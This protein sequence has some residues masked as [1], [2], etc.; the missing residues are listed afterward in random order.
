MT[1]EFLTSA[2]VFSGGGGWELGAIATGLT[3]VWAIE[4]DDKIAEVYEQNIGA[5][6]IRQSADRV[7]VRRLAKPDVLFASPPC[8][9]ASSARSPK[10]A[11]SDSANIGAC[12]VKYLRVLKPEIFLLEN[13]PRY[14]HQP[15]FAAV[16]AELLRLGYWM[17]LDVVNA[18]DFGVPQSR[19][20]II[21]RAARHRMLT[22]LPAPVAHRSWFGA[23]ED[24]LPSLET[25]YF[26]PFQAS[27]LPAELT[28]MIV[29]NERSNRDGGGMNY[30][31]HGKPLMT[32]KASARSMQSWRV[33]L[34]DGANARTDEY[35]GLT[36]VPDKRPAFT[37]CANAGRHAHRAQL[38]DGRVVRLSTRA[39]AR[40]Q[41]FPDSYQLPESGELACT[42]I[43]NAVPPLLA[44]RLIETE[45]M[46]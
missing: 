28:T 13:V 27:R 39:L 41:S 14:I 16:V 40:L 9:D 32:V 46:R 7:D 1:Q 8:K 36:I 11:P 30:A 34:T 20:R 44:Q 45:R 2:S 26:P 25:S 33:F 6:V 35:G 31:R 42:V 29:G 15:A 38:G 43:G 19:R 21:L 17:R 4:N 12:L 24:L 37:I 10:L 5:H 18:A 23:I 22:P 3:P